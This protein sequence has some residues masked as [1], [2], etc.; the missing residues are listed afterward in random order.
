MRFSKCQFFSPAVELHT[1]DHSVLVNRQKIRLIQFSCN[2]AF[3]QE[4]LPHGYPG[5]LF[6]L[7]AN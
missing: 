2:R 7:Y 3:F 6:A 1:G 4:V 5:W